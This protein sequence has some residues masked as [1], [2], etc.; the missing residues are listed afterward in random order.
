MKPG[1]SSGDGASSTAPS[2]SAPA[3]PA[4]HRP[5]RPRTLGRRFERA[6]KRRLTRLLV[7]FVRPHASPPP[8]PGTVRRLLAIRQ[9]NQMGDM[10]LSLPAL[11]LLRRTYPAARLVF[12]TSPLCEALLAGHPEIDELLVF[13]KEAVWRPWLLGP[14]LAALRRPRPDLAIVLGTVSFST[15]SALLAW[16]SGARWRAGVASRPFGSEL[17]R[18]IYHRELPMAAPEAHE[19]EHNAAPLRGLGID[20]A[21]GFPELPVP[22]AATRTAGEFVA[23]SFPNR[24]GPVVVVHPGAGKQENIWPVDR[25]AQLAR[26]LAATVGARVV[27]SEGP[28]DASVAA[29]LLG[30]CPGAVLWRADLRATLGLLH[31]ADVFVGNDT[32]M[33]HVA[34]AV[35]TPTV[36]VFGP[37]DPRRWSP[38]GRWV[39][40]VRSTSGRIEDARIEDVL[41]AA[42]AALQHVTS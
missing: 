15:T 29:R 1:N 12:V 41:E 19:V 21:P 16:A 8:A 22:A 20:A 23:R 24:P 30:A 17:S 42:I 5:A 31:H 32:G 34:A 10:V 7:R 26:T 13:R 4:A 39:R 27:V 33:A 11:R 14:F 36:A 3:A 35:G 6:A 18:A 2:P 9:H 38:A 40:C 28:R 25:F 37:T